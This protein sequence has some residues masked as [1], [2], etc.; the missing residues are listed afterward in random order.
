M[1]P[2]RRD[3][4]GAGPRSD[5]GIAERHEDEDATPPT[6]QEAD[7]SDELP[8]DQAAHQPDTGDAG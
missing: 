8:D 6:G 3:D 7:P 1:A 5:K 2:P 4:E